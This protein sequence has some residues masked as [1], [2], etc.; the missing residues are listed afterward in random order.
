MLKFRQ[1]LWPLKFISRLGQ[2]YLYH[3]FR[4]VW[5]QRY[6]RFGHGTKGFLYGLIGLIT[7]R[8]AIFEGQP[9]GGSDIVLGTLD[10]R[11]F[12]TLLLAILA[13]GLVGYA[14]W[15]LI[16]LLL[17]P[18]HPTGQLSARQIL[19]RCG[20]GFSCLTYL[21]IGY[22]AGRLAIGL[23]VDFEDTIEEVAEALF[24][25]AIGPW[26]LFASGTSVIL[27][28]LVY[29]YGAYSGKFINEFQPSMYFAVKNVT[30]FMGKLGFTT[31]GVSFILVGSYLMKA[32]YLLDKE[33]AGGFGEV[34][35]RLDSQ[36][37]GKVWLTAIAFGFLAY[38]AYMVMAAFYRR[39][40]SVKN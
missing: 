20:Y 40:P 13:V 35:D 24:E 15:R 12:G 30:V 25:V 1:Y 33:T 4:K 11:A 22:T 32:A 36:P 2:R 34:L 26:A 38:A 31:R 27:V 21:G 8:G 37:F 14:L 7:L 23:T 28:G 17:D 5:V 16:Q 10:D 19:Q 18:E 9:V 6:M 3:L 39:F 29:V